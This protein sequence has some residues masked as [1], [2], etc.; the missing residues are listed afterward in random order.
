M[1]KVKAW[2]MDMDD[3]VVDAIESGASNVEEVIS[4]VK[5]EL[6]FCDKSY[7]KSIYTEI[8]GEKIV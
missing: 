3:M 4:Y 6:I 1:G 5:S 2:M 7:I 8:M